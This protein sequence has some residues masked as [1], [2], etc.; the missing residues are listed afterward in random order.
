VLELPV[1]FRP[2]AQEDLGRIFDRIFAVSRNVGTAEHFVRRIRDRCARI[3]L[4][5]FGGR[6][7]HDLGP[8]L[9]L[10]SF[11]R[12]VLNAYRVEPDRVEII[13]LFGRGR[14]YEGFYRS[15]VPPLS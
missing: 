15:I 2:E 7:R 3:G 6:A 1:T 12:S 9:R 11:E 10:T 13:N 14:D 4:L 8:G 5:P